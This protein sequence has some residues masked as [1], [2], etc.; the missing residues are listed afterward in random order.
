MKSVIMSIFN[1]DNV[2]EKVLSGLFK[3]TSKSVNEYIFVLDGCNDKSSDIL[4]KYINKVPHGATYKILVSN[5]VFEIRSNNIGLRECSNEYAVIVQDDMLMMETNW[6]ERMMVPFLKFDDIW[7]VTARTTCSLNLKGKWENIKEGPVGHKYIDLKDCIYPRDIIHVGQVVN[8]GP[9]MVKMSVMK[10]LGYFDET[11]PG[12]IG[13]DDVDL[14]FKAFNHY[15][16]RCC[17][18]WISYYSPL[19]WGSCRTGPNT[20][21]VHKQMD[22]NLKE[23]IKRHSKIIKEWKYDEERY[24]NL[25]I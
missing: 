4:H 13:C 17:Q 10:K 23:I 15:N 2:L 5:N 22:I 1:K 25:N 7:A 21:Y 14:C 20:E 16:L 6:D 3:H 18:F 9:L 12:V 24:V 8:R 19:E 11:L